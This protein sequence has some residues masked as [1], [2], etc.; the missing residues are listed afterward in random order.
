MSSAHTSSIGCRQI[1]ASQSFCSSDVGDDLSS[2]RSFGDGS[3][4]S[5]SW[6]A[7][8]NNKPNAPLSIGDD[9]ELMAY[10]QSLKPLLVTR[11]DLF[12]ILARMPE[13]VLIA[14]PSSGANAQ[15]HE[16]LTSIFQSM[17][18][19]VHIKGRGNCLVF[20]RGFRYS[21]SSYSMGRLKTSIVMHVCPS[22]LV[23]STAKKR[24][25]PVPEDVE[26]VRVDSKESSGAEMEAAAS[27]E[28][29]E[30]KISDMSSRDLF[31]AELV[32]PFSGALRAATLDSR[33]TMK[34]LRHRR[35]NLRH[36]KDALSLLL[37]SD[38]E[39]NQ[40]Y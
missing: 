5:C 26:D 2:E 16:L 32:G 31:L 1:L 11:K 10:A 23:P 29:L 35:H 12:K 17:T 4:S 22:F 20:P 37:N 21:D 24:P 38:K 6:S 7:L 19:V 33:C 40:K 8:D 18:A 36:A 27:K 14:E 34:N 39:N 3:A 28:A 25:A 13:S 9:Q 15:F 30:V